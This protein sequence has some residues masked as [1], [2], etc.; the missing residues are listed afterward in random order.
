MGVDRAL[1]FG[2]EFERSR[3]TSGAGAPSLP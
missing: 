3:A 1:P 2:H